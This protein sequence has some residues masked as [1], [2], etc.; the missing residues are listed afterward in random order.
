[1]SGKV[2]RDDGSPDPVLV[3]PAVSIMGASSS[4]DVSF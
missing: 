4:S 1:M 3:F 2:L